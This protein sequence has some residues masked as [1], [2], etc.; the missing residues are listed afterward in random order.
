MK[1][2]S[3]FPKRAGLDVHAL[4]KLTGFEVVG[5]FQRRQIFPFFIL[6]EQIGDYD[7]A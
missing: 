6:T 7:V 4:T 1:H 2:R 5:E 3:E